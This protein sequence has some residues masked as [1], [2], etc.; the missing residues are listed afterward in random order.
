MPPWHTQG[1]IY[2]CISY[3]RFPFMN[4]FYYKFLSAT[5][6][7]LFRRRILVPYQ[8]TW[9]LFLPASTWHITIFHHND[10]KTEYSAQCNWLLIAHTAYG[11]DVMT[12]FTPQASENLKPVEHCYSWEG[13]SPSANKR[14]SH[15]WWKSSGRHSLQ[16][17]PPLDP[18]LNHMNPV[19][20]SAKHY[21]PSSFRSRHLSVCFRVFDWTV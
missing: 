7:P 4:I 11:F 10:V 19:N 3:Y 9:Q 13:N 20:S 14:I 21:P 12:W 1:L 18:K 15:V 8:E 2:L 5:F 17:G 6:L 16:K